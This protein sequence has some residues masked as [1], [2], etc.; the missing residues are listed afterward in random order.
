MI[1]RGLSMELTS[2][3]VMKVNKKTL[4]EKKNLIEQ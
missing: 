4:A 2:G 1:S 3:F